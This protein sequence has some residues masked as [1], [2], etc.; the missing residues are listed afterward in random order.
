MV[1]HAYITKWFS[2]SSCTL[3][4]RFCWLPFG[5][6]DILRLSSE[7]THQEEVSN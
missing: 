7:K 3:V 6:N 2:F 1:A 5:D 4:F